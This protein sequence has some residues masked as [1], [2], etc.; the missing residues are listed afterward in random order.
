M[1]HGTFVCIT[2]QQSDNLLLLLLVTT[3]S[4]SFASILPRGERGLDQSPSCAG[5]SGAG[6][7]LLGLP[8]QIGPVLGL[9]EGRPPGERPGDVEAPGGGRRRRGLGRSCG[10]A[11]PAWGAPVVGASADNR[12]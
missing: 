4:G 2:E 5:S 10:L 8:S 1:V 12:Q 9:P 11:E 6:A 3:L 7:V